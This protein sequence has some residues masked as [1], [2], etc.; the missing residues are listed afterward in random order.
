VSAQLPPVAA[1]VPHAQ[2]GRL[3][4]HGSGDAAT[5]QRIAERLPVA[6]AAHVGAAAPADGHSLRAAIESALREA[7]R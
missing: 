6:L 2:V 3:I 5:A 4:V 1:A 7:A